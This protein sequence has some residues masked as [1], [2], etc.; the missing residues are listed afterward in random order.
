M[1]DVWLGLWNINNDFVLDIDNWIFINCLLDFYFY[2]YLIWCIYVWIMYLRK[3]LSGLSRV[4][5]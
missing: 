3:E 2:K 1:F 4:L 5:G